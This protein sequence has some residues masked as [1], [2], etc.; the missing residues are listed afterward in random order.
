MNCEWTDVLDKLPTNYLLVKAHLHD[1]IS[2][3]VR[4]HHI[5]GIQLEPAV[6]SVSDKLTYS[7]ASNWT[8]L[9]QLDSPVYCV[10]VTNFNDHL[11]QQGKV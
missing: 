9:C 7:F 1:F 10:V 3:Q 8:E 11:D 2:L 4:R 5:N 6:H